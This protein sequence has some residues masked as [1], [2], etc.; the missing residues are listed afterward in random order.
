MR[1]SFP[2]FM[3]LGLRTMLQKDEGILL[4]HKVASALAC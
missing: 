4:Y 1:I 2:D 3:G